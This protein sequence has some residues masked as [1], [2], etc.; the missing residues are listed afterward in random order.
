MHGRFQRLIYSSSSSSDSTLEKVD[1][2]GV[3]KLASLHFEVRRETLSKMKT[4][5]LFPEFILEVWSSSAPVDG[6]GDPQEDT[7]GDL[8]VVRVVGL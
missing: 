1:F 4:R 3:F 6:G 8:V 5:L 2:S 7:S